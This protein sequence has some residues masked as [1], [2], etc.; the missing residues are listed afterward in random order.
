MTPLSF[1]IYQDYLA[2]KAHFNKKENYNYKKYNG[3]IRGAEVKFNRNVKRYKHVLS[4]LTHFHD[5]T[6]LFVSNIVA[7]VINLQEIARQEG[8]DRYNARMAVTQS[9][10]Y[11]F[12]ADLDNVDQNFNN[13]F[14]NNKLLE[15]LQEN[16]INLE[17]ATILIAITDSHKYF[18]N[19]DLLFTVM[20]YNDF[21]AYDSKKYKKIVSEKF[22]QKTD[23]TD[24]LSTD[25][26]TS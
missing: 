10:E 4:K 8:K 14:R 5:T 16:K 19:G 24:V 3:K 13:N 9:L 25:Q 23:K 21:L 15:L 20:K 26:S 22:I 11:K 12:K 6:G 2:V 1:K 18:T 17:T 7:N